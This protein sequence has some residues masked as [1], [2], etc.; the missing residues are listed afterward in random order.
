M[1]RPGSVR[2]R[3]VPDERAPAERRETQAG[4]FAPVLPAM[5]ENRFSFNARNAVLCLILALLYPIY[6][7]VSSGRSLLKLMDAMTVTGLLFLIAGVVFSLVQHGDFD[8]TEYVAKRSL[9]KGNI[10]PFDAF[11]SDKKEERKDRINYP[12]FTGLLLL[13]ASALLNLFAY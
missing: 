2:I 13:A 6:A 3:A 7:Y 1:L 8:I 12:F 9:R 4:G 5:S 10:K 11:R